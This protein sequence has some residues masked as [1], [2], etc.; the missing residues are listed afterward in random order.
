MTNHE[1]FQLAYEQLEEVRL[2]L[3]MTPCADACV[4]SIAGGYA[5]T[6][7]EGGRACGG[8]VFERERHPREDGFIRRRTR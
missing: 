7:S 8:F 2:K 1:A 4:R 5:W 6:I 3:N